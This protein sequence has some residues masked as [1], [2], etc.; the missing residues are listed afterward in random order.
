MHISHRHAAPLMA[1]RTPT[2]VT[3]RTLTAAAVLALA[4]VAPS[5]L[6]AAAAPVPFT[7]CAAAQP[8]FQ[9][10]SVDVEPQPLMP[11]KRATFRV[12]GSLVETL[13]G[14]SYVADVRYMGV[15]V[16]ER[17]GS[18]SELIALPAQ[19]G[20]AAFKATERLPR[21]TPEGS[22]ELIFNATDQNGAEL[23]CVKV[24]FSVG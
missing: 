20:P 12:D 7:N 16:L 19:P 21:N 4:A 23:T 9:A 22:Y 5:A 3:L 8:M 11:G 6:P 10:N 13:T 1:R 14:G 18:I 2:R 17:S 15:S 24:P